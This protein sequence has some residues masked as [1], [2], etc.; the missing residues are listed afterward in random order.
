MTS[1]DMRMALSPRSEE[2]CDPGLSFLLNVVRAEHWRNTSP[3][4]AARDQLSALTAAWAQPSDSPVDLVGRK[5]PHSPPEWHLQRLIELLDAPADRDVDHARRLYHARWLGHLLAPERAEFR[6]TVTILI[7]VYNRATMV[8]EAVESCLAQSWRPLE[9]LIVDD[10]STDELAGA[11]TR[12]GDAVRVVRKANGGVSSAR[13]AGIRVAKGDFI[14][15]L[16]SDNLLAPGAVV[17]KLDGFARFPDAELCYSL[18]K[19]EGERPPDVPAIPPPD[20]SANCPTTSLLASHLRYPFYISCVMLPRHTLLS[21]GGFEE[22]L[23]RGEDTRFW[24]KL[25]LRDTK[26]IGLGAQLTTRRLSE[27]SL[28]GTPMPPALQLVIRSRTIADLLGDPRS[29][30][31]AARSAPGLL[32]ILLRDGA[33]LQTTGLPHG[34]MSPLLAAI[35]R[36]GTGERHDGMSPLPLLAHLRHLIT[37]ATRSNPA[38]RET[39]VLLARLGSLVDAAVRSTAPLAR[40]D[41]SFWAMARLAR[42]GKRRINSY[43]DHADSFLQDHG[44]A[45]TLIDELLR[46]APTIPPKHAIKNYLTLRRWRLP[47]RSALWLALR[48]AT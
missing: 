30:P 2:S 38:M 6:P 42:D 7:P 36:L 17:R 13:N 18:A 11:L 39:P 48:K 32:H 43:F 23:R 47:R 44:P 34:G 20:G 40:R 10:G 28:S 12:F 41:V 19:I 46:S 3:T 9:I 1:F 33:S 35:D 14:H 37:R 24:V 27:S 26:V 5:S 21:T 8:V 25:A 16:D 45:L 29:W 22:D 15:F 31:L 4:D